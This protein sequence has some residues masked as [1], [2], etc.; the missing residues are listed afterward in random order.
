MIKDYFQRNIQFILML[1]VWVIAGMVHEMAA[2]GVIAISLLLMKRKSRYAEMTLGFIFI[3]ILSDSRQPELYFAQK[4]KDIYLLILTA[5]YLLDLKQFRF[6]NTLFL[7]FVPFLLWSFAVAFRGPDI[8]VA[9]QKTLSYGLLYFVVPAYFIKSFKTEGSVFLRDFIIL[10][11]ILL[12]TGL[13]LIIIKPNFVFLVG[14]FSGL[15]GNPN[16]LG[17]F[18]ALMVA[19]TACVQI[20]FPTLFHKNHLIFIYSLLAICAI[21]TG[22]RNTLMSIIIFLTF[23]KFYRI[24]YWYGFM[25]VIIAILLYQVVFTNLPSILEMLG[26]SKAL[27]AETLESGSGRMVAWVFALNNLNSDLKL[28]LFGGGFSYDEYLYKANYKMLS[29]LGHQGGVH[30]TGLALWLNTGIIGLVLWITGFF[31]TIFNAVSVSFTA[32]P[33]MYMVLFSTFFE[34]WLMGSLN[35]FHIV[36]IFILMIITQPTDQFGEDSDMSAITS[37]NHQG[38]DSMVTRKLKP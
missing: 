22:S 10:V 16:G 19:L 13:L 24:S 34:A 18:I 5:F 28:F 31:R 35:P 14:R 2:L 21:L 32:F 30:N 26:L 33:L 37:V 29:M 7:A 27:R 9:F 3:L 12:L 15:F 11:S 17:I 38:S 1:V 36:Y 8:M 23:V 6:R 20:K 25:V 4:V